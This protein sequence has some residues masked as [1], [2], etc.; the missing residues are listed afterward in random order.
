MNNNS[1]LVNAMMYSSYSNYILI[2]NVIGKWL[3]E[4]PQIIRGKPEFDS[5][6]RSFPGRVTQKKLH[7]HR[8]N[9]FIY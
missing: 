2:K 7:L 6:Q 9:M 5:Q 4:L 8:K 3:N 1:N